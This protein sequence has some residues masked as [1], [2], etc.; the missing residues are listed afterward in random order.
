MRKITIDATEKRLGRLATEIAT[1]LMGK[2][3]P[4]FE[5]HTLAD[6]EVEV[7]NASLMDIPEKKKDSKIYKRYS[8]YPGGQKEIPM[9]KIIEK[10]GY[11]EVLRLAVLRMLPK[12]RLQKRM[13]KRLTIKD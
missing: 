1:K 12:N 5:R 11:G 10:K 6:V 3:S 9:R 8:G 13:M 2:D 7:I 4:D